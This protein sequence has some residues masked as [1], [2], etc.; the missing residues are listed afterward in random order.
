MNLV[1]QRGRGVAR[2]P[3]VAV[4]AF[5][6]AST[7]DSADSIP[8]LM[9]RVNVKGAQTLRRNPDGVTKLIL[10]KAD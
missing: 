7:M 4:T 6:K 1:S 9:I 8:N 3:R 10:S 5:L 2:S